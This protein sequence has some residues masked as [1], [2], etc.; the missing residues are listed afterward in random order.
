ML[1][2]KNADI[3]TQDVCLTCSVSSCTDQYIYSEML[4]V[5]LLCDFEW[6]W[7]SLD[8]SSDV[9]ASQKDLKGLNTMDAHCVVVCLSLSAVYFCH[10]LSPLFRVRVSVVD[11]LLLWIVFQVIDEWFKVNASDQYADFSLILICTHSWE[12]GKT[13]PLPLI[14]AI[15]IKMAFYCITVQIV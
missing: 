12:I 3:F 1:D 6:W 5:Y 7:H 8:T 9:S 10:N 11:S 4:T 15:S 2:L 13:T 14:H